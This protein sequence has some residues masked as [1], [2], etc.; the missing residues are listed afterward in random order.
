MSLVLSEM[1]DAVLVLTLNRPERLNAVVP[2]LF[3]AL[4]DV[5]AAADGT[6]KAVVLTGAGKGFCAGGD[7]RAPKSDYAPSSRRMRRFYHP[8]IQQLDAL[9][10]PLI[11]AVN[12]PALGAGLSLA[13]AADI[14]LASDRASF[15]AGFAPVGLSPDNGATHHLVRVLGYTRAFE[16]LL[17]GARLDAA[18]AH[19]WG[20]VN[21]V[22]PHGELLACAV[23]LATRLAYMPGLAVPVTKR[24]LKDSHRRHLAEQ[25]ELETQAFDETSQHP[26]RARARDAVRDRIS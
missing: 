3:D 21:E 11:A 26:D 4:S 15:S 14:R 10:I 9:D 20:L 24:L 25:L 19:S 18:A 6:V 16:L 17:G 7:I 8:V 2:E 23:D 1:R 22:V 13:A 5:L 12:G